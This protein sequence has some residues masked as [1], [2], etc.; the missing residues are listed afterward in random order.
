MENSVE[1]PQFQLE[2]NIETNAD[3][4]G[5]KQKHKLEVKSK[6][7]SRGSQISSVQSKIPAPVSRIPSSERIKNPSCINKQSP[8]Q[9]NFTKAS[10]NI[11]LSSG[12]KSK[13]T[14]IPSRMAKPMSFNANSVANQKKFSQPIYKNPQSG[15]KSNV[16]T[17]KRKTSEA[18]ISSVSKNI[19]Q[20]HLK[21]KRSASASVIETSFRKKSFD[22]DDLQISKIRPPDNKYEQNYLPSEAKAL[23]NKSRSQS[24]MGSKIPQ[25][26]N[27]SNS[28]ASVKKTTKVEKINEMYKD[29]EK[30]SYL[31]IEHVENDSSLTL[32]KSLEASVIK[33]DDDRKEVVEQKDEFEL[34]EVESGLDTEAIS[35]DYSVEPTHKNKQIIM[36]ESSDTSKLIND[37]FRNDNDSQEINEFKEYGI[38]NFS[39]LPEEE[40]SVNVCNENTRARPGN[41]SYEDNIDIKHK[42]KLVEDVENTNDCSKIKINTPYINTDA[43]EIHQQPNEL[44]IDNN[45][46]FNIILNGNSAMRKEQVPFSTEKCN[47]AYHKILSMMPQSPGSNT[48][49]SEDVQLASE[50]GNTHSSPYKIDSVLGSS[51]HSNKSF[52]YPNLDGSNTL[53]KLKRQRSLSSDASSSISGSIVGSTSMTLPG[54][55]GNMNLLRNRYRSNSSDMSRSTSSSIFGS[56]CSLNQ[57]GEVFSSTEEL[58]DWEIRKALQILGIKVE[59]GTLTIKNEKALKVLGIESIVRLLNKDEDENSQGYLHLADN[60]DSGS[61]I[62]LTEKASKPKSLRHWLFKKPKFAKKKKKIDVPTILPEDEEEEAHVDSEGSNVDSTSLQ[63]DAVSLHDDTISIQ[64]DASSL[65]EESSTLQDDDGSSIHSYSNI[66]EGGA[67]KSLMSGANCFHSAILS[68]SLYNTQENEFVDSRYASIKYATVGTGS[69]ISGYMNGHRKQR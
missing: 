54:V 2:T 4:D 19:N 40:I 37:F 66:I 28:F 68:S 51:P 23:Q 30:I 41:D 65:Q 47:R 33:E 16:S 25:F 44:N 31:D 60:V 10:S 34:N 1:E 26:G 18:S 14:H 8:V 22:S 46:R 24:K 5:Y 43:D 62:D 52:Q 27:K 20:A 59:D 57:D 17:N 29:D 3:I 55:D 53:P 21:T 12:I 11:P 39:K 9:G 38:E 63:G 49:S 15:S 58:E 61:A 6:I 67:I 48:C 56:G 7:P 50:F 45:Q 69:P 64:S 42:H 32:P 35:E 36:E 13:G